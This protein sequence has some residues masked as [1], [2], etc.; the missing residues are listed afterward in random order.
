MVEQGIEN[1]RVGGSIPS[2]ATTFILRSRPLLVGLLLVG[3]LPLVGGCGDQ[4]EQLC[5]QASTRLQRCKPDG[6]DWRDL[7]ARSRNDFANSC[8]T[9]WERVSSDLT[10]TEVREALDVCR[11][12]RA[13]LDEL[14]CDEVAAIYAEE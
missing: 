11:D 8:R 2:L 7:G 9:D 12:T 14:S 10:A 6:M 4:C 5:V 1:P 3:G 13:A